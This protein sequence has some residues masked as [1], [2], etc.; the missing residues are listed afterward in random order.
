VSGLRNID[1]LLRLPIWG[2]FGSVGGPPRPQRPE[3]ARGGAEEALRAG[4]EGEQRVC[5]III[6]IYKSYIT[7]IVIDVAAGLR[8]VAPLP[9]PPGPGGPPTKPGNPPPDRPP[10][11]S[12]LRRPD[13]GINLNPPVAQPSDLANQPLLS[14][15]VRL[16]AILLV[17]SPACAPADRPDGAAT[18]KPAIP[19]L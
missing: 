5:N 3:E 8:K 15:P 2:L 17:A 11:T 9:P 13:S 7:S 10:R 12:T 4:T 18:P 1:T 19:D 16:L 14:P 6:Y